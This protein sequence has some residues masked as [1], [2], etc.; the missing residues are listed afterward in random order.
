MKHFILNLSELKGEVYT[1]KSQLS[2]A[3]FVAYLKERAAEEKTVKKNFYEFV[4]DE[5]SQ[6]PELLKP[7]SAEEIVKQKELLEFVY[8][9]LVPAIADEKTTLWALAQP[10]APVIFYGT[11]AFYSLIADGETHMVKP[12]IIKNREAEVQKSNHAFLY[13]FILS[14]LYNLNFTCKDAMIHSFKD[15]KSGVMKYYRMNVDAR[16]IKVIPSGPLPDLNLDA[17]QLTTQEA[18]DFEKLEN[19]LPLSMFTFE[20][21]AV[22]T[23]TDVTELYSIELIKDTILNHN[24]ADTSYNFSKVIEALKALVGNNHVEFGLLPMF[25][26]NSKLVFNDEICMNSTLVSTAKEHGMAEQAY[27]TIAERYFENPQLLFFKN[28][29][30][31]VEA[32]QIVLKLLKQTGI[33]SYALLPVFYS[34]KISGVLEVYSKY[35]GLLDDSLFSK[36]DAAIPLL[37]QLLRNSIDSFNTSIDSIVREKF[38]SLQPAVQWK[39]NEAAWHYFRDTLREN[40]PT[41]ESITF[42]EV[43]PLYGAI[44]IRNSTAERAHAL[45]G[46][47]QIRFNLLIDTLAELK[48]TLS[49]PIIDEK[50]FLARKWEQSL[51]DYSVAPNEIG[52]NF[53]LDNEMHDFLNHF[54]K[55]S[56][57]AAAIVNKYLAAIDDTDG[58]ANRNRRE[59]ELSMDLINKNVNKYL[60][61][62]KS[63]L[64][65]S[66]P[67]Y[68]EKYRSDGVE[69]D[70]YIGQSIAPEK[71]F[72]LLYFHNLRLWQ[73]QSMTEITR[74]TNSLLP[75]IKRP[76]QTTQLIFIH[77]DKIDISFRTD[78]RRFDVE[79]AYNIRYQVI[80][81]RIDK[82]RINN[83]QERLT[84]PGKI[85]MVYFNEPDAEEYVKYIQFMQSQGQLLDDLEY[86]DLENLQGV[87]G[88]KAL[89]V[90]VNL[91]YS[92]DE[93]ANPPHTPEKKVIGGAYNRH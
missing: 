66:Y 43:Y 11:E 23:L 44:D 74:L 88:L 81:K 48:D 37:A 28:I 65:E 14:K 58:D 85:A 45:M 46:D 12:A 90:G 52:L 62:A 76:L 55:Y 68:F 54:K 67:S 71:P 20:G 18:I 5:F 25:K 19:I 29:T 59:L 53:F 40:N 30:P 13:S 82:V 26:V 80:K 6:Y 75:Q 8:A 91:E 84:Q 10:M 3:P 78:E 87:S 89:R 69:Y 50:I 15:E 77:P 73:L 51:V 39:F 72:N 2:F 38:T 16:F 42:K 32:S 22:L 31:E 36:L 24:T 41:M 86:L 27:M 49:L 4:L 21:I 7:I 60:E 61:K 92:K 9:I 34:N 93:K 64:Q 57:E 35:D 33:K 17:Q 1:P 70:I 47:L 63:G 56:A 83:T 79:G